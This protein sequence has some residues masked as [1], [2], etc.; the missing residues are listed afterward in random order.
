M[1]NC[2][3][4]GYYPEKLNCVCLCG[5]CMDC[6]AKYGHDNCEKI[7]NDYLKNKKEVFGT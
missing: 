6:I 1:T 2:R 3:I 5:F 7:A 4:C